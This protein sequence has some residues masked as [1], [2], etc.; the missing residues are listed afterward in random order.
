[1]LLEILRQVKS[2]VSMSLLVDVFNVAEIIRNFETEVLA[3]TQKM[4]DDAHK[5]V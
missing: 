5:H 1:M 3:S 2:D 4:S